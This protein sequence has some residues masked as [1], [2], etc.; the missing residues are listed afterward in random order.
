MV[1]FMD[2]A[3]Y[4]PLAEHYENCLEKFGAT[5]QGVDWPNMADLSKRFDVLLGVVKPSDTI[6]QLLDLGCGYGALVDHL[7]HRQLLHK[8]NYHGMDISSKMIAAAQLQHPAINFSQR[9]ILVDHQQ[10]DSYDY[11]LMNGLF[12]EKQSLPHT[13]MC[14]FLSRMLHT[15]FHMAKHGIAFNVMSHHVDWQRDDLFHLPFDELVTILQRECSRH[16]VIR[17][18]YGLYEYSVYVYKHPTITT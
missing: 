16:F 7:Q 14:D 12:T 3:E 4:K 9:D 13:K 17:A 18:D 15:S 6:I 10:S 11:I 5:P 2:Y 1:S 8:F